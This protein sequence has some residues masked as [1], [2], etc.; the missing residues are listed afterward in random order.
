MQVLREDK[1]YSNFYHSLRSARTKQAY[2]YALTQFMKFHNITTYTSLLQTSDIED[3]IKVYILDIVNQGLS[4]STM[5]IF[6]A[7]V[8]NFFEMN[9]N[10]SLNWRKLKRFMGEKTPEN[11]DRC[12]TNEEIQTLLN[13]SDLRLKVTILLMASS[14][15]RIGALPHLICGHLERRGDLYKINVY[16]GQKGKGQYYTFCTPEAANAIDTYLQFRERCGE[17]I[18]PSSPLFRKEFDIDF[19]ESARNRV[20]AASIH[21]LRM[22]VFNSLVNTGLRIVDRINSSRNRKEVKMT[23]GFRKFFETMLVNSGIH[24]LSLEN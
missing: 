2:D 1:I 24:E 19:H 5:K 11:E 18:T 16:K 12:Y 7:A 15:M 6:L 3:K 20:E 21:S 8:K 4:T 10:E 23:H 13:I 14:G 17:K 9:D 22:D